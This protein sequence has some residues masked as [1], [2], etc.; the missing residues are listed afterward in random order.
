MSAD[1]VIMFRR[2]SGSQRI[3]ETIFEVKEEYVKFNNKGEGIVIVNFEAPKEELMKIYE[4][5]DNVNDM[6]PITLNIAG[7]GDMDHYFK[8]MGPLKEEDITSKFNVTLQ[9]LQQSRF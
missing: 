9:S 3:G 6:E 5:F 7:A 1:D 4:F 8:G 2:S